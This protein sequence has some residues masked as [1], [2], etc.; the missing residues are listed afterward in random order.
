MKL[1]TLN[2]YDGNK[3]LIY[4]YNIT[5]YFRC[6]KSRL[7]LIL[8]LLFVPKRFINKDTKKPFVIFR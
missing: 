4:I 6:T 7:A 1:K 2:S 3:G 8:Y 5:K